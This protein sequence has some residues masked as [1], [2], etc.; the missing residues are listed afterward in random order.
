MLTSIRVRDNN[1]AT[2]TK[3]MFT[4]THTLFVFIKRLKQRFIYKSIPT[5]KM[6][7]TVKYVIDEVIKDITRFGSLVFYVFLLLF[8]L[9]FQEIQLFWQLLFGFFVTLL[10]VVV[11][12][13]IYFKNRP[14]KQQHTNFVERI[15]ASSFPSLHA[16]RVTFLFVVFALTVANIYFTIIIAKISILVLYSRIH[17]KKHDWKDLLAGM[18]LGGFTYWLSLLLF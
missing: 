16:A 5:K 17:L 18:I 9:A 13:M 7:K 6:H 14:R 4:I 2:N 11:I 10:G 3:E 8:V 1:A 15:D 12:R